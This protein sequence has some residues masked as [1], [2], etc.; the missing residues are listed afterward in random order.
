[1]LSQELAPHFSTLIQKDKR[2]LAVAFSGGGDST[3]LLS[4]LLEWIA[5]NGSRDVF[6]L[7]V[8]HGLRDGSANEAKIAARRA[9]DM[10][11]KVKILSWDGAKPN[12][13]IQERARKARY[14][15]LGDACRRLG[16]VQLFLG[17]NQDDQAET[18]YMRI[19]NQTGWRGMA[20]MGARRVSPL[21]PEL[22]GV[23]V[24]R[25][26]LDV[27]R[28]ELR[29]YCTKN[30]LAYIDDPSNENRKFTRIRVRHTLTEMS[31]MQQQL[32]Q[33]GMSAQ[34]S[35]RDEMQAL[36]RFMLKSTEV[37]DWGGINVNANNL[38]VYPEHTVEEA[39]KYLILPVSGGNQAPSQTQRQNLV[40][41]LTCGNFKGA[42]LG[43][44]QFIPKGDTILLVRDPGAVLGRAEKPMYSPVKL[45]PQKVTF[46]DGRFKIETRISE[47]SLV[48]LM[49][50]KGKLSKLQKQNLK[51]IPLE[52][53]AGLPCLLKGG[54][55]IAPYIDGP[56]PDIDMQCLVKERLFTMV[57]GG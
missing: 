24:I 47:V 22:Y 1:M 55:V 51:K 50:Y 12:T 44:V 38:T 23:E 7:I 56:H 27:A 8:D 49:E 15:L 46:W 37:F 48:P 42:T 40:K 29:N 41:N 25:P 57:G 9:R 4:M 16:A 34:G 33:V 6:A 13:A 30:H 14:A 11:A 28:E 54:G 53:H 10:G 20:G 18:I 36:S 32:L 45:L 26:L 39:L 52:A 3:A 31:E 17:H 21:W 43:G 2:P 5:Q 19:Q 35:L